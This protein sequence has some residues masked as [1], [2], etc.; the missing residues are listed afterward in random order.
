MGMLGASHCI[1]MHS[2]GGPSTA[3]C[4]VTMM[5]DGSRK[6]CLYGNTV[7]QMWHVGRE[8]CD[9]GCQQLSMLTGGRRTT[10]LPLAMPEGVGRE[11][12]LKYSQLPPGGIRGC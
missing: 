3:P 2:G 11:Q 10:S 4:M 6:E 8:R 12:P 9:W 7:A 1:L 5:S